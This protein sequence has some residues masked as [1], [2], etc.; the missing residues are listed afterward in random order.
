MFAGLDVISV[1]PNHNTHCYHSSGPQQGLLEG[2][3][4]LGVVHLASQGSTTGSMHGH[5]FWISQVA[6]LAPLTSHYYVH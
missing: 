1:A 6:S 5:Y 2:G 3:I 4:L